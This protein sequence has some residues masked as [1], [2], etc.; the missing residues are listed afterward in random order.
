M[1]TSAA[2]T[3]LEA[4]YAASAAGLAQAL[5]EFDQLQSV[6]AW[7]ER[8]AHALR[9][10][11]EELI[12]NNVTHGRRPGDTGW[13]SVRLTQSNDRIAL[14]IEDDGLPFDPTEMPPPDLDAQLDDRPEGGLGVFLARSLSSELSYVRERGINR[15]TAVFLL[16]ARND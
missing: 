3:S 13:F 12:I 6:N 8:M 5:S 1:H 11:L 15:T 10:V 14:T 7:G 16:V 4:I 9:L 2:V